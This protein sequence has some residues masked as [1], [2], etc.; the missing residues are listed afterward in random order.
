MNMR[1][2]VFFRTRSRVWDRAL[3]AE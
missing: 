3:C 2:V 1:S